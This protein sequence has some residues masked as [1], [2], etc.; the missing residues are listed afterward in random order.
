VEVFFFFSFRMSVL[1]NMIGLGVGCCMGR[2]TEDMTQQVEVGDE[3]ESGR[4][5]EKESE[6]ERKR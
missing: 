2:K 3:N 4:V 5:R 1:I 6:R